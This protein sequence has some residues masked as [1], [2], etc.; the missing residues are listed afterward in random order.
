M[1]E[2]DIIPTTSGLFSECAT[3]H[4]TSEYHRSF[5]CCFDQ[6]FRSLM[7]RSPRDNT[8]A[9]SNTCSCQRFHP[10]LSTYSVHNSSPACF[11]NFRHNKKRRLAVKACG[12]SR[13]W[14]FV[15]PSSN[16]R[17]VAFIY[18]R[19]NTNTDTIRPETS[20]EDE[21]LD[22]THT[23]LQGRI[24][25]RHETEKKSISPVVVVSVAHSGVVE[26]AFSK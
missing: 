23:P 5:S 13:I 8:A 25:A 18:P 14:R 10:R 19:N 15:V 12:K 1:H 11:D 21:G 17:R 2:I 20:F 6:H 3:V 7:L 9:P 4:S 22:F 24:S 16:D 26:C